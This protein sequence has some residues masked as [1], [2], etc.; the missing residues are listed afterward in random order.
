MTLTCSRNTTC[1]T[2]Q[3]QKSIPIV[4]KVMLFAIRSGICPGFGCYI[5]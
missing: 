3:T 2:L 5:S 4:T 1:S